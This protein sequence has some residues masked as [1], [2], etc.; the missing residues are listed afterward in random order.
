M[1]HNKKQLAD[2]ATQIVKRHRQLRRSTLIHPAREWLVG[3]MV[4]GAIVIVSV[5][6]SMVLYSDNQEIG[7]GDTS[8]AAGT[9]VYRLAP[10]EK[11]AAYIT[12]QA[13]QHAALL[14][15]NV[16]PA[17]TP[18]EAPKDSATASTPPAVVDAPSATTA[19]VPAS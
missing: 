13:A 1:I 3:L 16:S 15:E 7:Q 9:D 2:L 12:K 6:W 19:V 18:E 5:L 17:A 11:A 8:P 4:A 10:I 14:D